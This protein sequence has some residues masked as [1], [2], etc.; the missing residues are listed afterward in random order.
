[1]FSVGAG[2]LEQ[3][4]CCIAGTP[5]SRGAWIEVGPMDAGSAAMRKAGEYVI[6]EEVNGSSAARRRSGV[7]DCLRS[8]IVRT[9]LYAVRSLQDKRRDSRTRGSHRSRLRRLTVADL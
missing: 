6:R 9:G 2:C 5:R 1:M 4:G 8:D 3:D 7:L